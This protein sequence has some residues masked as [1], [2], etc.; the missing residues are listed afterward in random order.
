MFCLFT[1]LHIDS[2]KNMLEKVDK[3]SKKEINKK[4]R[5]HSYP[6]SQYFKSYEIKPTLCLLSSSSA[7]NF[8]NHFFIHPERQSGQLINLDL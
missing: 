8:W 6:N 3:N 1:F 7:E 5:R 4:R 2:Y